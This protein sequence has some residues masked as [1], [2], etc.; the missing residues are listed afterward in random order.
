ML[1]RSR[2]GAPSSCSQSGSLSPG[3]SSRLPRS[4]EG[5]RATTPV[6]ISE[7]RR[8]GAHALAAQYYRPVPDAVLQ[9]GSVTEI[10]SALGDPYTAYLAPPDYKL[11]RQETASHY[12]GIGVSVLP[13]PRGFV[14]VSLRHGPAQRAGICTSATRSCASA[15]SR[16]RA[17]A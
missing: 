7:R 6:A 8:R 4:R 9:L 15:A 5:S 10:I 13:S 11:V 17:S 14:V 3:R 1:A 12:T 16:R 2:C